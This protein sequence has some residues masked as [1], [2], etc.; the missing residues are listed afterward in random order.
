MFEKSNRTRLFVNGFPKYLTE[1]KLKNRFEPYGEI[2]DVTIKKTPSGISRCFGYIGFAKEKQAR[3]A[4]KQ[5]DG[6]YIDTH[7][8][9]V[10]FARKKGS[11]DIN[12]P[13]SKYSEGSSA[14]DEINEIE[15]PTTKVEKEDHFKQFKIDLSDPEFIEFL[16]VSK[17]KGKDKWANDDLRM[18][19]F[20]KYKK[21][22]P[23]AEDKKMEEEDK[24]ESADES[25]EI[26]KIKEQEALYTATHGKAKEGSS[27]MDF[28]ESRMEDDDSDSDDNQDEDL[29]EDT[30]EIKK[31]RIIAHTMKKADITQ[32]GRLFLRNLNYLATEDDIFQ[33]MSE[34]G[35]VTE[36]YRPIDHTT[37]KS[38]G[39]AFVTF[40]FSEEAQKA[41]NSLNGTFFQG[42]LLHVLPAHSRQAHQKEEAV[43]NDENASHKDKVEAKRKMNAENTVNWNTLYMRSDTVASAMANQLGMSKKE[44]LE[45]K[46]SE[47][48][49]VQLARGETELIRQ[50]KE[51]LVEHGVNFEILNN[52]ESYKKRS[53]HI[54]LVKNLPPNTN[55]GAVQSLF[56]PYGQLEKIVVA[57]GGVMALVKFYERAEA[58]RAFSKLSFIPFQSQILYL[59]WAP[60]N[61]LK[62]RIQ[63]IKETHGISSSSS[64]DLAPNN[65]SSST[66]NEASATLYVYN[67]DYET[68]EADVEEMF[69]NIGINPKNVSLIRDPKTG[70][71]KGYGF[72]SCASIR[73][74]VRAKQKLNRL[75][76]FG[77]ML[78]ID[79]Q[80]VDKDDET[81]SKNDE[82]TMIEGKKL[83]F[84]KLV[85]KNLAFQC[86]RKE[87]FGLFKPFGEIVDIRVPQKVAGGS[88][89]F[90]F[91]EYMTAEQCHAAYTA[92]KHTHLY[93]RHLVLQFAADDNSLS[94]A[95]ERAT[96]DLIG[97]SK[98]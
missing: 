65:R 39:F 88:R 49:A 72:V 73:D 22:H 26:K 15:K 90:A 41:L 1:N 35:E 44:F 3:A 92:L 89:G 75:P 38:L 85:V 82:S 64:E 77:R 59:E 34:F 30:R 12:R 94:A 20:K 50:T 36:V 52:P 69:T 58:R 24:E 27:D 13:W 8:I 51:A 31:K 79:F 98:T 57:P 37:R 97:E 56:S 47:N 83:T 45:K 80:S 4:L 70:K 60:A 2:T 46:G 14:Y 16:N 19:A 33:L 23:K 96:N 87:L 5:L 95:R 10:M 28:L 81:E 53:K 11:N 86:T 93:G 25:L 40:M 6:T 55:E 63:E 32:T 29:L 71:N 66:T 84:K 91:V 67:L 54:I 48:M 7:R 17:A 74:A 62:S 42:R 21:K 61:V 43:L 78:K 18:D 68:M 9:S 76:L